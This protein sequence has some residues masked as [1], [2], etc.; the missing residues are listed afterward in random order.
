ME[1][2]EDAILCSVLHNLIAF[3]LAFKVNRDQIRRKANRLVGQA[4]LGLA[5]TDVIYKLLD[6]FKETVSI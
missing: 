4:H 2:E 6:S 1:E 5:H 3:M